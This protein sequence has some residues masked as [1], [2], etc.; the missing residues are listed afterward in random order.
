MNTTSLW[1]SIVVVLEY[2]LLV[3]I[4]SPLASLF[5]ASTRVQQ[6]FTNSSIPHVDGQHN[7]QY[8]NSVDRTP[9]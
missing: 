4:D 7:N 9:R 3:V 2:P 6:L 5:H 1:S 8:L